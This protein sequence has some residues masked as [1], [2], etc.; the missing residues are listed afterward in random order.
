MSEEWLTLEQ[1]LIEATALFEEWWQD[2]GC[3]IGIFKSI[4]IGTP[5]SKRIQEAVKQAFLDGYLM[6]ERH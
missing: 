5:L 1:K 4:P 2:E 3:C 6:N